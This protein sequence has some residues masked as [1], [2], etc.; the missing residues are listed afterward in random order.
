MTHILF[1]VVFLSKYVFW[2]A[3]PNN[4]FEAM[5]VWIVVLAS[6][7]LVR[8]LTVQAVVL[9]RASYFYA[10]LLYVLWSLI[11]CLL[12]W[13]EGRITALAY[14][15]L[16]LLVWPFIPARENLSIATF[17]F[18][19]GVVLGAGLLIVTVIFL[20]GLNQLSSRTEGLVQVGPN[21]IAFISALGF[22]CA[23]CL[24]KT[25]AR[26][27]SI[28]FARG[29]MVVFAG[30]IVF[31]FSKTIIVICFLAVI[32]SRV[33]FS[34][35]KALVFT[36]LAMVAYS[37]IMYI[38]F[39]FVEDQVY[40]YLSGPNSLSTLSGRTLLWGQI[41]RG[42]DEWRLVL[43]A[44]FN[45]SIN[46]SRD[47]GYYIFGTEAFGQAHNA[48][49]E[50]VINTGVVGASLMVF[51]VVFSFA[52]AFFKLKSST[53]HGESARSKLLFSILLIFVAR[54]VTEGSYS[55]PGTIDAGIVFFIVGVVAVS[56]S[57][58][59]FKFV[60]YKKSLEVG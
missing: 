5:L 31:S 49:I 46:V 30:V 18:C 45:S 24:S 52:K 56:Y 16:P 48:V 8:C 25:S 51:S 42:L 17:E 7:S 57:N 44:G 35:V 36:L 38:V 4:Y 2:L 32:L 40:Q 50:A 55:Q 12:P 60:L 53:H 9:P 1:W 15:I 54:S 13:A 14:A 22:F 23:W 37:L 34:S 3:A 43:G 41:L 26:R 27:L 21:T 10:M 39:V 33:S 28:Y 29:A 19:V 47:A 6:L 59:A 11:C 20:M 58:K